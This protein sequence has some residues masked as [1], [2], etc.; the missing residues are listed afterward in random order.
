MRRGGQK[1]DLVASHSRLALVVHYQPRARTVLLFLS[2]RLPWQFTVNSAQLSFPLRG[3]VV[4]VDHTAID[5]TMSPGVGELRVQVSVDEQVRCPSVLCLV[6]TFRNPDSIVCPCA[7]HPSFLISLYRTNFL[8]LHQHSIPVSA[9]RCPC[10]TNA[11][12]PC[13]ISS[14]SRTHSL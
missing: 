2:S 6:L 1:S 7:F 12:Y 3:C 5:C 9:F 4:A 11:F 14:L 10:A 8:Y 13:V